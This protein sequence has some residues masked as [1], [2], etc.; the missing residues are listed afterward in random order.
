MPKVLIICESFPPKSFV[1]GLRPAMMAKYLPSYGWEPYVL[2][3]DYG[4]DYS[5]RSEKMS[6]GCIVPNDHIARVIVTAQEEEYYISTRGVRGM[7]RDIVTIEKSFP[8]G[9]FDKMWAF[10]KQ[11]FKRFD[12]DIIWTTFPNF[13]SLRLGRDLSKRL[14]IPWIAD[15]RDITEQENDNDSNWR[16]YI[17]RQRSILRRR[18]LVK[19]ASSLTSVSYFHCRTLE[20]KIG[21][22]CELIYNGYDAGLFHPVAP[23]KTEIFS[24]VYMGRILSKS[25]RNPCLFFEALD[26]LLAEGQVN[27]KHVEICFY[28]TEV[29]LLQ[30][31]A[32][33]YRSWGLCRFYERI[34]YKEVPET[35]NK[36]SVLLLLSEHKRYGV[37]TTKLFEYLAI[38]RPILCVRTEPDS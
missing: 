33:D 22:P 1:G 25:L 5:K 9:V 17:F 13:P 21:K 6:L 3:R 38:E 7:F 27:S 24:I 28:A 10:T 11:Y 29:K 31:I 12:F 8:P 15:F 16:A 26:D 4:Q 2:T 36:A 32:G 19:S 34:D 18:M 30:S 20:E 37:L 35:L 23:I 14:G